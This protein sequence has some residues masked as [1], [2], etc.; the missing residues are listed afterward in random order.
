MPFG[1]TPCSEGVSFALWAPN[2]SKVTLLCD[3]QSY[4]MQDLGEGWRRLVVTQAKPGSL[5][6]YRIDDDLSVPDPAS[7]FQPQG[8]DGPSLVIDPQSFMWR[9]ASWRGRPWE[10]TVLYEAHVGTATPE[11]TYATLAD[12]LELL[13]DEGITAIELLPLADCPGARNWGYD[14]VLPFA[15]NAA[16]GHPDELKRFIDHAHALG[17][18]VFIDVVY[19]HF[20]PAGNY[21][22]A[23]AKAFFTE[24]HRTP[25]GAGL[26]FDGTAGG[27][28]RAFFLHNALY[29]LEEF[30]VD[31]LRFDAVHAILDDSERHFLT[32]IAET[33]RSLWPDRHIHLVLENEKN[34]AS[35]LARD[36]RGRS[37][38]FD[39]QWNDDIHNSWHRLLTGESES[40]YADFGGDTI[41]CLGRCLA[42]GFA[43]QGEYSQHGDKPRGEPSSHLPPQ[44]FVAFLQNHDQIGN[45]AFGERLSM[46]VA[47]DKLDLA[48]ALFLLAPQI[49]LLFMGED[50]NAA[51]PF[52]FFVDFVTDPALSKAVR[53]GRRHEFSGFAAY[54][55]N[56]EKIPDPTALATFTA[57]KLDW[58][59]REAAHQAEALA[60]TCALLAL[61]RAEILPLLQ[62]KFLGAAYRRHGL[63]GLDVCWHF[64]AGRLGFFANFAEEETSLSSDFQGRVIWQNCELDLDHDDFGSDRSKIMSPWTGFVMT[65]AA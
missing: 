61:R 27:T 24:R 42:E 21:L 57:S 36:A 31:G 26:N 29:W 6:S 11:G 34:E 35:R 19:N 50:W 33:I 54:A 44:A 49:P 53:E 22:H 65:G 13:R 3:G 32:E 46:L 16:Y 5:Y 47:P 8:I 15:P 12:K 30:N 43:Y 14:G 52:L 39:A 20:G 4:A 41:G 45:R 51:Q 1:G 38:H 10:E 58:R 17:L 62:S 25:W 40:Y 23:Y 9:D 28:V 37:R 7:R 2:A 59:E 55:G 63:G 48:R 56:E 64:A 18:M 60:K